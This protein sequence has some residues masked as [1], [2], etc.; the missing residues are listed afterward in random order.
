MK[1][2]MKLTIDDL[3]VQ[4]K[5][6]NS[7]NDYAVANLIIRE[8]YV[9]QGYRISKSHWIHP[10]FQE[11][12][13]IQPPAVY[14]KGKWIKIGYV[15]DMKLWE[16]LEDKIYSLFCKTRLED[17]SEIMDENVRPEEIPF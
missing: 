5:L 9:V 6:I 2:E 17:K 16:E 10:R 7:K 15:L 1:M 3:K 11:Q 14:N 8:S 12:I 4:L 13:Q